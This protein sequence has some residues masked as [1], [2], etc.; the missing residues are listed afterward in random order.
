[1]CIFP[2]VFMLVPL[3][4]GIGMRKFTSGITRT[5][6]GIPAVLVPLRPSTYMYESDYRCVQTCEHEHRLHRS[7]RDSEITHPPIRAAIP[8]FTERVIVQLPISQIQPLIVRKE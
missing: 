2:K 4:V 8:K 7:K 3:G 1:M 6:G 5:D